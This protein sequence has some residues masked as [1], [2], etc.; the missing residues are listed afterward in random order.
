MDILSEKTKTTLRLELDDGI[1][2]NKQKVKKQNFTKIKNEATDEQLYNTAKALSNLF[3]KDTI[4]IKKV[5]ESE[6]I[7]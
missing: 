5:E 3:E 1:V 7:G 4:S 6:L 2:N